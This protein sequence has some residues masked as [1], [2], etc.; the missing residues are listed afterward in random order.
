MTSLALSLSFCSHSQNLPSDLPRPV[1]SSVSP[2]LTL[3]SLQMTR[4]D[5]LIMTC[6]C[7]QVLLMSSQCGHKCYSVSTQPCSGESHSNWSPPSCCSST[8]S[9][10]DWPSLP[11]LPAR[12]AAPSD[13]ARRVSRLD[14]WSWTCGRGE[15]CYAELVLNMPTD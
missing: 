15:I 8:S 7:C 11:S 3:L 13:L 5:R 1:G 9:T 12:G 10:Q 2:P 14:E 4:S 6:K